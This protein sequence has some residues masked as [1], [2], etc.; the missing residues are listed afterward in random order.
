MSRPQEPKVP[1]ADAAPRARP[2]RVGKGVAAVP[3]GDPK[4]AAERTEPREGGLARLLE[5][6]GHVSGCASGD[7]TEMLLGRI[8]KAMPRYV[9]ISETRQ[10]LAVARALVDSGPRDPLEGM[11]IGQL[12]ALHEAAMES[13]RR[14]MA[15]GVPPEL[16]ELNLAS[17]TRLTRSYAGLLE[18]LDRHRGNGR[19]QVVRVERVTVESGAQAIV[20]PVSHPGPGGRGDGGKADERPHAS[21]RGALEPGAAVRGHD[22]GGDALPAGGGEGQAPVPDARRCCGLGGTARQP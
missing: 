10:A 19:P 1:P 11:L 15:G 13:L 17:A 3:A 6:K 9:D 21:G 4:G 2:G 5:G 20:G 8:L 12:V 16:R 18:A 14:A 22:P 7:F